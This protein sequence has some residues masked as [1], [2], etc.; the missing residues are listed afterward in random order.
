MAVLEQTAGAYG[1]GAACG[2]DE[3]LAVGKQSVGKRSVAEGLENSGVGDVGKCQGIQ[4]V[5]VHELF[6]DVSAEHHGLGNHYRGVLPFVEFGMVLHHAV[7]ECQSAAF[8]SEAAVADACKVGITVETVTAK[9]SHHALVLHPAVAD[10]GLENHL[11]VVVEVLEIVDAKLLDEFCRGEQCAAVQPAADVVA[12][13]MVEETL[14]G[15]VEDAVLQFLQVAHTHHF[16][17]GL[18][19]AEDEIAEAE[20]LPYR[21]A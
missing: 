20:V 6:K 7:N 4:G 1:D 15:D 5:P 21:F 13:D 9:D 3:S 18:G 12:A 14:G 2:V 8:A 19:I 10:D 11:P 16:L 17:H